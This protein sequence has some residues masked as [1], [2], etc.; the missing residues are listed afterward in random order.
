MKKTFLILAFLFIA[1]QL[2]ASDYY[3]AN[4]GNDNNNGKT[5]EKAWKSFKRLNN[6]R[7]KPGDK[8]FLKSGDIFTGTIHL[9]HSGKENKPVLIS[10]FGEGPKP[11]V[12]GAIPILNWSRLN[13]SLFVAKVET[14]VYG[15]YK[16][17]E[18][19]NIARYPNSGFFKIDDGD[20]ISL[21]DD[22]LASLSFSLA[23]AT[24]RIKSVDWQSETMTVGNH[25]RDKIFFSEKMMYSCKIDYGYFLDNKYEFM[26]SP[27][28]WYY[29][30]KK[31]ELYFHAGQGSRVPENIKAVIHK[32]GLVIANGVKHVSIEGLKIEKFDNACIYANKA[33]KN[34]NVTQCDIKHA[35]V[36]GFHIEPGSMNFHI[37]DNNISEVRGR[38]IST[39]ELSH[40]LIENNRITHIGLHP[41]YGFNG[42]NNQVG[43]AVLRKEKTYSV[44]SETLKYLKE[45]NMNTSKYKIIESMLD[46][47]YTNKMYFEMALEKKLQKNQ[48]KTLIEKV[49]ARVDYENDM[50]QKQST[51]NIIRRNYIDSTGYIGIRLDGTYSLAEQNI[52]KNTILHMN[53]G[54]AIY[55]WG[56]HYDY[57]HNNII[58]QNIV[59]N[60]VG[61]AEATP[62][63]RLF[64]IGIY[65]DNRCRNITIEKNTVLEAKAG[66]LINDNSFDQVIK[67]NTT[68]DNLYGMMFSEYYKPGTL[69]GCVTE[70][71]IFF[72]KQ[73]HQ[74]CLFKESR[75]SEDFN[76][77][78]YNNNFYGSPYYTYPLLEL[79]YKD[80]VRRYH[81]YTLES[82]QRKTGQDK[83]SEFLAPEDPEDRGNESF[84]L[85]NETTENKSFNIKRERKC[86]SVEGEE[87]GKEVTLKPFTSM[88]VVME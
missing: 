76:P 29:D 73:R 17:D 59:I 24:A 83:D 27:G 26:D 2:R 53:D 68:Y 8:I 3:I 13:D 19:L 48:D 87:L 56:Q 11:V 31:K 37:S 22:R 44:S 32:E 71:N 9:K 50:I 42:V 51:K 55:C 88:I 49:I 4:S 25:D 75:I 85:I 28:E 64:G 12:S 7:L 30:K 81:E 61:S 1:I 39:L 78:T 15:L 67:N 62:N 72:S 35:T 21:T 33:T 18:Y 23:G 54:G 70:N 82:W 43:I 63:N 36:Y 84:I 52:V 65:V 38:G 66:I 34:I 6:T 46:L 57:T 40:S 14:E 5:P 77:S 41:C 69:K 10:T 86:Y 80:E 60:P 20:K 74:R 58:R 47:P 45:Q 79:T 16:G